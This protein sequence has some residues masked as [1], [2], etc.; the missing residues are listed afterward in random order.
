MSAE[1]RVARI[2]LALAAKGNLALEREKS[3]GKFD[4]TNEFP[5]AIV[6]SRGVTYITKHAIAFCLLSMRI[7]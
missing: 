6:F 5:L 3:A 4:V 7:V 1:L 2:Q